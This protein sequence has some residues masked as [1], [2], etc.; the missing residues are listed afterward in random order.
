[1]GGLKSLDCTLRDASCESFDFGF[2]IVSIGDSF[3]L[4][5]GIADFGL[6][7]VNR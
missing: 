6:N 5:F 4:G 1:M 3:D 2:G 7:R